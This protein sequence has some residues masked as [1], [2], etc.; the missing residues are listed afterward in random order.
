[1]PSQLTQM[2]LTGLLFPLQCAAVMQ[3]L[4]MRNQELKIACKVEAEAIS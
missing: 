4:V 1:M 2:R 3:I